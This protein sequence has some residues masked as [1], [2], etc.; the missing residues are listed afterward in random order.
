MNFDKVGTIGVI[1][2][3]AGPS[4]LHR[5]KL[6]ENTECIG[7]VIHPDEHV[8]KLEHALHVIEAL[9]HVKAIAIEPYREVVVISKD[10]YHN[11]E[12]IILGLNQ[13]RVLMANFA[14]LEEPIL[15][16]LELS[17]RH[18]ERIDDLV[19]SEIF[20]N[21]KMTTRKSLKRNAHQLNK[22]E[23]HYNHRVPSKRNFLRKT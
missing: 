1:G 20:E 2:M 22:I 10:D 5:I 19:L 18:P 3:G 9:A 7:I 12:E 8:E 14:T 21:Q 6:L 15:E 16:M 23:K 4:F 13:S 11:I 17:E